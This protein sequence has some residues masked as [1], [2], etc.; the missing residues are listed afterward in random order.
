MPIGLVKNVKLK[1]RLCRLCSADSVDEIHFCVIV[2]WIRMVD[3]SE[4]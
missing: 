2:C 3:Y 4:L 1:E